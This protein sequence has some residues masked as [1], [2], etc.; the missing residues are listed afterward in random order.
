MIDGERLL[1]RATPCITNSTWTGLGSYPFSYT[2][3][4][5][6]DRLNCKNNETTD[7]RGCGVAR[8]YYKQRVT[9][10]TRDWCKEFRDLLI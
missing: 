3:R 1:S 5:A 4:P 7:G 6:T 2:N 10:Q 9:R 8:E